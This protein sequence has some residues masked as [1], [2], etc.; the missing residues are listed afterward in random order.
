VLQQRRRINQGVDEASPRKERS[1][2]RGHRNV[3]IAAVAVAILAV[4]AVVLRPDGHTPPRPPS[5]TAT[6]LP[7][8]PELGHGEGPRA[9]KVSERL[10]PEAGPLAVGQHRWISSPTVPAGFYWFT[11]STSSWRSGGYK[12][13]PGGGGWIEKG[14]PGTPD[15]AVITFWRPDNVYADPCGHTLL[16]PQPSALDFSHAVAAIHGTE[17]VSG[18]T[19]GPSFWDHH[20]VLRIPGHLECD[21]QQFYL[22][23]AGEHPRAAT[24]RGSTITV[25]IID[26]SPRRAGRPIFVEAQ[27]YEG[28]SPELEREVQQILDSV[29]HSGGIG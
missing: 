2:M 19:P 7:S 29:R 12:H 14:T 24:A 22:W 21:P 23:A 11:V 8:L 17:L 10:F 5:A 16:N 20:V 26:V 28:A 27:T 25:S 4:L 3:G 1:E 18:P 9:S 15:G 6:S 13:V